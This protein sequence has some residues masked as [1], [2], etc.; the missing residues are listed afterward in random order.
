MRSAWHVAFVFAIFSA[1]S[2]AADDE[3][4]TVETAVRANPK[5]VVFSTTP[6]PGH[7][8]V[9]FR[10]DGKGPPVI[11]EIEANSAADKGGL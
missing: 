4:R 1:Q 3:Y 2:N 6:I 8:G 10:A 9:L 11:D 7:L 5:P